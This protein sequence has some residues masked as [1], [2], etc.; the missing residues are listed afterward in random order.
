MRTIRFDGTCQDPCFL[1]VIIPSTFDY[2]FL[3]I[4]VPQ[5]DT[6]KTVVGAV[7]EPPLRLISIGL[8]P[9]L[10]NSYYDSMAI[11]L[12]LTDHNTSDK[13]PN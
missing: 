9:Q 12:T 11:F 5:L 3:M 8:S 10:R 7:R 2:R 4:G 13:L 6:N 1:L